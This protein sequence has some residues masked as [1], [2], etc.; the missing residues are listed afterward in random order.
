[1]AK[2]KL[3]TVRKQLLTRFF[4]TTTKEKV[5]DILYIRDLNEDEILWQC[6]NDNTSLAVVTRDNYI[7]TYADELDM[8]DEPDEFVGIGDHKRISNGSIMQI[9]FT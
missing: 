4:K 3:T 7:T 2:L 6:K 9:I 5:V 1:M 8:F